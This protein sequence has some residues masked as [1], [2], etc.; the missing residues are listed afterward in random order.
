MND[1]NRFLNKRKL[2]K[3]IAALM[4]FSAHATPNKEKFSDW[5]KC[6]EGSAQVS[7]KLKWKGLRRMVSFTG[8]L[9]RGA[10]QPWSSDIG[11]LVLCG[12]QLWGDVGSDEASW[13][14]RCT[15][16]EEKHH[17][18]LTSSIIK[19]IFVSTRFIVRL[20]LLSPTLGPSTSSSWLYLSLSPTHSRLQGPHDWGSSYPDVIQLG[21]LFT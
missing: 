18:L 14:T 12:L 15:S 2:L 19:N 4:F 3:I 10:K 17:S 7:Q 20:F 8:D 11:S 16:A 13:L 5:R 21:W 1:L 6:L 9:H